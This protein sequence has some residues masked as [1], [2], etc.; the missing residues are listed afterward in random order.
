MHD[1]TPEHVY[2]Q[3]RTKLSLCYFAPNP[4][5]HTQYFSLVV[6]GYALIRQTSQNPNGWHEIGRVVEKFG[7][8][9]SRNYF[10]ISPL[11][12]CLT[13]SVVLPPH[14][15]SPNVPPTP[16][17]TRATSCCPPIRGGWCYESDTQRVKRERHPKGAPVLPRLPLHSFGAALPHV[18]RFRVPLGRARAPTHHWHVCP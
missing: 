5:F 3:S 7:H 12:S 13:Q 17:P 18:I 9:K 4:D 10:Q 1:I 6:G 8:T 16:I 2:V 11:P 14:P 15:S